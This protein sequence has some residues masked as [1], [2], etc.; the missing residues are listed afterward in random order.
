MSTPHNSAEKGSIAKTVLMS[1]D[2]LRAKFIAEN[3]LENIKCFN[4]VRGMLGYTGTYKGKEISVMGHGMGI[5]SMAIYSYELFKFY[6]VDNIIRIGSAGSV[7][8][9]VNLNDI[10]IAMSASTESSYCKQFGIY[11]GYSPT[12]DFGL[13]EKAVAAAREA[14]AVFHVGNVSSDDVFYSQDDSFHNRLRDAGVLCCEMESA[15]LYCNA[16][17]LKKHA[18]ALLTISDNIFK[19]E[20]LSTEERQT[21]FKQMMEIALNTVLSI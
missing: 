9:N 3:Y 15:A 1:G 11:E 13:L 19:N 6:D 20:R 16:A 8:D 12:A 17:Y 4:E 18:L 10:V 5:P 2:P 7:Q 21:G 14:D